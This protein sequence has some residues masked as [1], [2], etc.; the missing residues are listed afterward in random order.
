MNIIDIIKKRQTVTN[1]SSRPVEKDKIERIARSVEFS[2]R[3]SEKIPLKVIVV[4]NPKHKQQIRQQ[5]EQVE[6][7]YT[8]GASV[9]GEDNG[10]G[11][12]SGDDWKKPFLEEAPYLL[13]ICSLSGQPYNAA[14]TWLALGKVMMAASEEGLGSMCY[15][16]QMPTFLRKVLNIAA[17]FM[18]IAIIPVGYSADDLFPTLEPQE[19][20]IFRN[21]FSGRFNWQ[22]TN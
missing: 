17:R 18:P 12:A 6:R 15:S 19:E 8:Q 4:S 20:R 14:S 7:A 2:P 9:F 22:K 1:F 11:H 13:V 10:D 16:P 3:G 21:L 5:A